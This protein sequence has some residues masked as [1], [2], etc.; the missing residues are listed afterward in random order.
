M[1][2]SDFLSGLVY[3]FNDLIGAIVPGLFLLGG[4]RLLHII[5][6]DVDKTYLSLSVEG[7]WVA[8]LVL[9]YIVGHGL[10]SFHRPLRRLLFPLKGLDDLITKGKWDGRG[11]EVRVAEAAAYQEFRDYVT[12]RFMPQTIGNYAGPGSEKKEKPKLRGKRIMSP[13]DL[14]SIAMT[15]SNE[16]ATLGR[17]FMFI[18]LFCYGVAMA[19]LTL[20]LIYVVV[21]W[22]SLG[23]WGVTK[24]CLVGTIF[25]FFYTRGLEFELRAFNTP[26]PV[27]LGEVLVERKGKERGK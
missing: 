25:Y 10:L 24:I 11:L 14:R 23:A 4:L 13:N 18:S 1:K 16:A 19:L 5:P 8:V 21:E 15:I 9:G 17:R 26:F 3:F 27:A 12:K 2:V 20:S 7:Q 6:L 22:P